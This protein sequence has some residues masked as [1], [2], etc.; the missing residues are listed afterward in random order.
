M[1]DYVNYMD[2]LEPSE[3]LIS[4][5]EGLK[6]PQKRIPVYRTASF[7]AALILAVGVGGCLWAFSPSREPVRE[8][9][10][11]PD[12]IVEPGQD[13]DYSHAT[14][15]GGGY[16]IVEDGAVTHYT[17]PRLDFADASGLPA[18]ALDYTLGEEN[19]YT[20]SVTAEDVEHIFGKFWRE[21]LGLGD[22]WVF[23]DSYGSG[24][25]FNS[26]DEA[27]GLSFH[28]ACDDGSTYFVELLRGYDVPSCYVLPD[29]SYGRTDVDGVAV[30]ILEYAI[31][32]RCEVSFFAGGFGYRVRICDV[33][34]YRELAARFVGLAL[35]ERRGLED[36]RYEYDTPLP[37][38][39]ADPGVTITQGYDPAK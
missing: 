34:N 24:L 28:L 29:D 23:Y 15:Y 11:K 6:A 14:P 18:V 37:G 26:P 1:N 17:Y 39:P 10:G 35:D 13:D 21:R 12:I 3:E 7:A 38:E 25:F 4:R 22:E 32:R 8:E 16:D 9:T 2:R 27:N 33:D 30:Q 20:R 31:D 19:E 5:L 36:V